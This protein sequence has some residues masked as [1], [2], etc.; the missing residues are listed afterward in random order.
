VGKTK[1]EPT[2][3]KAGKPYEDEEIKELINNSL[4]NLSIS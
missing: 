4:T 2:E 1:T 3:I